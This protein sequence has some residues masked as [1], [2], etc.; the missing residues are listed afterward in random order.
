M[1]RL[2]TSYLFLLVLIPL[3]TS[4][5]GPQGWHTKKIRV[6]PADIPLLLR[7]RGSGVSYTALNKKYE[8][9][10]VI[11]LFYNEHGEEH[12]LGEITRTGV[13][14]ASGNV[15]YTVPEY[16]KGAYVSQRNLTSPTSTNYVRYDKKAGAYFEDDTAV[17]L[18]IDLENMTIK[19]FEV[20]L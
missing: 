8:A 7:Y 18:E 11:K 10:D 6:K 13:Y 4:C 16:P 17:V 9:L 12:Y 19:K 15:I 1:R 14:D 5:Q 2:I 3:S 20:V